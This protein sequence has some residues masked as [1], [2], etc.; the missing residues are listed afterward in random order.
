MTSSLTINEMKEYAGIAIA[1]P[2]MAQSEACRPHLR[3]LYPDPIV[4]YRNGSEKEI[5]I[6]NQNLKQNGKH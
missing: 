6:N 1:K 4:L 3:Q 5:K 2:R